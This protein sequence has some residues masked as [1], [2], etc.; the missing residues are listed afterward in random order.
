MAYS[1]MNQDELKE[2]RRAMHLEDIRDF[3]QDL[4]ND[5]GINRTD[6]NMKRPFY[7]RQGRMVVGIFASEFRKEKGFYFELINANSEPYSEERTVY[8][9]PSNPHFEQEYELNERGS[10][11]V[12]IEELR[13]IN[14]RSVAISGPSATLFGNPT[15]GNST[16]PSSAPPTGRAAGVSG[17]SAPAPVDAPYSEMTMRDYYAM[18]SGKPVSLKA[19]LN[20]LIKQK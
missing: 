1:T 19:W 20:E 14:V 10:Y 6:F 13:V 17:S 16:R 7:D 11:L 15:S 18:I 8:R 12:P 9:I 5:L 3:H 2:S 4:I